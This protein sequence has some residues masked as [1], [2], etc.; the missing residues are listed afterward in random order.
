MNVF[1]VKTS[2]FIFQQKMK[3][4]SYKSN[5]GS[6]GQPSGDFLGALIFWLDIWTHLGQFFFLLCTQSPDDERNMPRK[7]EDKLSLIKVSKGRCPNALDDFAVLSVLCQLGSFTLAF[8][9]MYQFLIICFLLEYSLST[10]LIISPSLYPEVAISCRPWKPLKS[11]Y[12]SFASLHRVQIWHLSSQISRTTF[13]REKGRD[14]TQSYDK[15]PYTNRNVKRAKWQH[16][17]RHKKVRLNSGC[18]P[19]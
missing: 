7:F 8:C 4:G 16:K 5:F 1:N 17:Q 10:V 14:L 2:Y 18:R 19:T 6:K 15:S 13:T 11:T 12:K 3:T 9:Y